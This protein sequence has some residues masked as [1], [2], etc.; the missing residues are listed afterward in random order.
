[1]GGQEVEITETHAALYN[2]RQKVR[3][4][5]DKVLEQ[6]KKFQIGMNDEVTGGHFWFICG[7]RYYGSRW[8]RDS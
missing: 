7:R 8:N 2:Q 4:T 6:D 5:L 1:M 3:V